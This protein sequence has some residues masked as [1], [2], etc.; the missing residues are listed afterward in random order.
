MSRPVLIA[1]ALAVGCGG[2]PRPPARAVVSNRAPA[3]SSPAPRVD[4]AE[5]AA[6]TLA[7]ALVACDTQ[8][9]LAMFASYDDL[10]A[11]ST[12]PSEDRRADYDRE[13]AEFVAKSCADLAQ[14]RGRAISAKVV[15][16]VHVTPAQHQELKRAVDEAT[17][18]LAFDGRPAGPP[19]MFLRTDHGF[20]FL[21]HN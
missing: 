21:L 6:V 20:R 11:M 4:P 15:R 14:A 18:Q 10:M 12:K 9:A 7:T 17:V 3:P 13:N 8:A 19:M 2:S 16:V 5:R 1:L